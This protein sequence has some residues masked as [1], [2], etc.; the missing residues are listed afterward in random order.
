M[1]PLLII[2]P[3]TSQWGHYSSSQSQWYCHNS[4][5]M[6]NIKLPCHTEGGE[7]LIRNISEWFNDPSLL[8][9]CISS[10]RNHISYGQSYLENY[11]AQQQKNLQLQLISLYLAMAPLMPCSLLIQ[12][13]APQ[14][15]T[16]KAWEA[17][18]WA[19]YIQYPHGSWSMC[20][21]HIR[22]YIYSLSMFIIYV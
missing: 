4:T 16:P 12:E 20:T 8:A 6:Y 18:N 21:T 3:V 14:R 15:Q 5:N 17:T 10:L 11:L 22:T 9:M 7:E 1:I 2:I 13:A 19:Q